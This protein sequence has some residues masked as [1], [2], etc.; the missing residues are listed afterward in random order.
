MC[1]LTIAE[2]YICYIISLKNLANQLTVSED[3]LYQVMSFIQK[4]VYRGKTNEDQ[5]NTDYLTRS[6]QLQG[7]YQKS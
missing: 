6:S 1:F 2:G 4:Y 3:L 5:N 7:I